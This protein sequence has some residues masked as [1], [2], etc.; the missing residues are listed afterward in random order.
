MS[1]EAVIRV[2]RPLAA[3]RMFYIVSD[4]TV[5]DSTTINVS[6]QAGHQRAR[7]REWVES[8][9]GLQNCCMDNINIRTF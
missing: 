4:T 1:G 2:I 5:R 3:V 6:L 7:D 8:Q 9:S